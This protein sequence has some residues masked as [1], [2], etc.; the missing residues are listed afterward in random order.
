MTDQQLADYLVIVE[1]ENAKMR[2]GTW[3]AI[4]EAKAKAA[5]AG[6]STA[7][8]DST[9]SP[10]HRPAN[11]PAQPLW[12]D[13]ALDAILV[14]T[15]HKFPAEVE[16]QIAKRANERDILFAYREGLAYERTNEAHTENTNTGAS[17]LRKIAQ[18]GKDLFKTKLAQSADEI[19]MTR[20]EQR[21]RRTA[22]KAAARE[23]LKQVITEAADLARPHL[24]EFKKVA[25]VFVDALEAEARAQAQRFHVRY[26]PS[27]T[28]LNLRRAV[29]SLAGRIPDKDQVLFQSPA[30]FLPPFK[31]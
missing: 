31:K 15:G 1:K 17:L 4:K 21:D 28:I 3:P 13:E 18:S 7:K 5:A 27:A 24:E 23:A 12:D 19:A 10:D 14:A 8:R 2:D 22:K 30:M 20:H 25:E 29:A 26:E 16:A 6:K 11:T 9:I